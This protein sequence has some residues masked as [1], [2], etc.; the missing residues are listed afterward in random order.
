MSYCKECSERPAYFLK[1]CD[2][3]CAQFT[4]ANGDVKSRV[5]ACPHFKKSKTMQAYGDIVAARVALS[6]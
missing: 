6:R 5:L 3:A 1:C 2:H 4:D